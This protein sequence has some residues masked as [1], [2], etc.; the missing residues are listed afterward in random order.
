MLMNLSFID[1]NNK[2]DTLITYF[3][4]PSNIILPNHL[5]VIFLYEPFSL[6][7]RRNDLTVK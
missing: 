3:E 5:T 7:L 4:F 6:H 1:M 2:A